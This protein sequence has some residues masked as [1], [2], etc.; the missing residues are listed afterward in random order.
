M[1]G[2]ILTV[3]LIY[4]KIKRKMWQ[5]RIEKKEVLL[6]KEELEEEIKNMVV[7]PRQIMG[8]YSKRTDVGHIS[9]GF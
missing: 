9:L 8:G 3:I 4:S 7:P 2:S 6:V 5:N 1:Q